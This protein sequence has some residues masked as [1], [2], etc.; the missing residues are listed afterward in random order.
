MAKD[1]YDTKIKNGNITTLVEAGEAAALSAGASIPDN[2]IKQ[3]F[4]NKS[5][6]SKKKSRYLPDAQAEGMAVA[7]PL[8]IKQQKSSKTIK[9]PPIETEEVKELAAVKGRQ[10]MRA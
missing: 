3:N 7:A 9:K 2:I 1:T 4:A 6:R 5:S 10:L 8:E